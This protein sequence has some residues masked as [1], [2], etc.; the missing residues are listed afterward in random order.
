MHDLTRD[1]THDLTHNLMIT[2]NRPPVGELLV[3]SPYDGRELNRVATAGPEHVDD[4][5]SV[6]QALFRDRNRWLSIP[7]RLAILDKTAAI[8][9]ADIEALTL[10]AAGEAANPTPIPKSRSY[11]PST[12][13][14]SAPKRCAAIPAT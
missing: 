2:S 10:L 1:L 8:M 11:A 3:S 9:A 7:E 4:A 12:A 13:S 14:N 6:A 5:L